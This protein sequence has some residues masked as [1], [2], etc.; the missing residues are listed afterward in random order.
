MRS[1]DKKLTSVRLH[2]ELFN[3]F[4]T[5]CISED[6]TFQKLAERSIFLYL[7]DKEFKNK[8]TTVDKIKID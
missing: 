6:F 4:K 2:P 8:I 7:T 1:K 3:K 5:R